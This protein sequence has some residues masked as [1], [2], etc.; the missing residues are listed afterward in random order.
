[1]VGMEAR[2]VIISSSM[3]SAIALDGEFVSSVTFGHKIIDAF[4]VTRCN[5]MYSTLVCSLLF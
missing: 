5:V 3:S 4:I 1:M 2:S